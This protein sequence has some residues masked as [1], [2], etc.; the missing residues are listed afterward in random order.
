MPS[1]K[2]AKYFENITVVRVNPE[3]GSMEEG[4]MISFNSPGYPSFYMVTAGSEKPTQIW[5]YQDA[6]GFVKACKAVDGLNDYY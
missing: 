2:V 4:L 3:H 6:S 1:Q 5:E